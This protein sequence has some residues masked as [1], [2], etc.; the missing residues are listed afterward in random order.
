[1][2]LAVVMCATS[3]SRNVHAVEPL[4]KQEQL[5]DSVYKV[6]H[7]LKKKLNNEYSEM[8]AEI[9]DMIVKNK[10]DFNLSMDTFYD[11]P[12]PLKD[13]KYINYLA[14]Y[15]SCK[16][17][18]KENEISIPKLQDV[19]FI[20]YDV[21]EQTIEEYVPTEIDKYVQDNH[22][23][24]E[25]YKVGTN[26]ILEPTKVPVYEQQVNG[27]WKKTKE[28]INVEPEL[29]ET[30]YIKVEL[31]VIEP[32]DIFRSFN[33][34]ENL[35]DDDYE[36]RV[37]MIKTITSNNAINQT[38]TLRLP[39]LDLNNYSEYEKYIT[40]LEGISRTVVETALSLKD[41]IPYEW[42]GKANRPGYDNNWWSYNPKNGLQRGLDCSGFVQWSFMTSGFPKELYSKLSSTSEL[43]KSDIPR[44]S[45]DEL[46]PGDIGCT[47]RENSTNHVGIYV[48][49]GEWVHCSSTKKTVT[50]S[51]V[52]FTVFFRPYSETLEIDN[53]IS[54]SYMEKKD[55]TYKYNISNCIDTQNSIYYTLNYNQDD[56]MLL[57]K[58]IHHEARGEGL[59]GWIGVGEVVCNRVA[60]SLYPNSIPEVI[61]QTGQFTNNEELADITPSEEIVK[62][63]ELIISGRLRVFNN[64]EVLY[65]KNPATTN[66]ITASMEIDWGKHK[67]FTYIEHHAF[68]VQ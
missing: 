20:T 32:E 35:V 61:F 41:K 17:Y 44:I 28:T 47:N 6:V 29:K 36:Q 48:G 11:Q 56:I 7:F 10:Y 63:A 54:E 62:V 59:N 16:K 14:A 58:L 64:A 21:T 50:V 8:E 25:Y 4:N 18:A 3:I 46:R 9:K 31:S 19:D 45:M 23:L 2:V 13:A 43:L 37:T 27:K 1:M 15:M 39:E 40:D 38:V 55:Y 65:F 57:A 12:N 52:D 60:S 42:G 22:V 34:D 26:F 5:K 33:I 51:K 68:Y 30:K 66:G 24:D 53:S 67:Y 49:N